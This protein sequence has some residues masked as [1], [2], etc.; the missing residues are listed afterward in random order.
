MVFNLHKILL[1]DGQ[2]FYNRSHFSYSNLCYSRIFTA[3]LAA[4]GKN[5]LNTRNQVPPTPGLSA[6]NGQIT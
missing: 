1:K 6:T 5:T 2:E 4:K 3:R